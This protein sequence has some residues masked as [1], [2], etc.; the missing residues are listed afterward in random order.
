MTTRA[1][2]YAYIRDIKKIPNLSESH[3]FLRFLPRNASPIA[4]LLRL[5]R[6]VHTTRRPSTAVT[7]RDN[8]AGVGNTIS[9]QSRIGDLSNPC[10]GIRGFSTPVKA[11]SI[12]DA[13]SFDESAQKNETISP[14]EESVVLPEDGVYLEEDAESRDHRLKESEC[15]IFSLLI[16]ENFRNRLEIIYNQQEETSRFECCISFLFNETKTISV[17]GIG[18]KE[19]RFNQSDFLVY[20]FLTFLRTKRKGQQDKLSGSFTQKLG[21]VPSGNKCNPIPSRQVARLPLIAELHRNGQ[22]ERLD[23]ALEEVL[24]SQ[25]ASKD[26]SLTEMEA[27][28]TDNTISQ[29]KVVTTDR[30]NTKEEVLK[31]QNA[32]KDE[33]FPEKK[34]TSTDNAISQQKVVT[35]DRF[36]T[37]EEVLK[38]QNASKDESFPQKKATSTDN[39]ISHKMAVTTD[40]SNT[41]AEASSDEASVATKKSTA[42]RGFIR[43]TTDDDLLDMIGLFRNDLLKA[44]TDMKRTKADLGP[45]RGG[46]YSPKTSRGFR[47][48]HR[49]KYHSKRLKKALKKLRESK[50]PE[51]LDIRSK[52]ADLPIMKFRQ[53]VLDLVNNNPF[54]IIVA[55]TGSGKSTQVPQMILDDAIDREV[56]G[57]C[58]ILCTQ[59]RR[60][61]TFRLAERISQERNENTGETVGYIVRQARQVSE[62]THITFCTTGVLL[63]ILQDSISNVG[64]FS[65]I[66]ID[67]VHVRDIGIDFVMLLLRNFVRNCQGNGRNAPKITLMSATVDTKLFSNYFSLKGPEGSRIFAPHITIPGRQYPVQHHYLDEILFDI[68]HSPH[69]SQLKK[70]LQEDES[71]R[72]LDKHYALFGET[73][74]EKPVETDSTS[75][76]TSPRL[77]SSEED[78]HMPSGLYTATILHILST[79][80]SGSIVC[81]LPGLR[82]IQEVKHRLMLHGNEMNLD[83]SDES[84]FRIGVLHS[85]LPEEQE[86][87]NLDVPSDCRRII[88]STDIAEA[89]VTIPDIK[90]VVDSGK[91]NQ[92]LVDQK[93]NCSRLA[94]CWATQSNAKQRAGRVGRVQ[95]GDYYYIGTKKRYDSL[96]ITPMPE[97]LRGSLLDTCLRAKSF[98]G[99]EPISKFLE[100]TIEPPNNDEVLA[101]VESLKQLQ[102]LDENEKITTLG[103]LISQ[104]AL[105]PHLAKLVMLGIIFRCLDPL[106]ILASIGVQSSLFIRSTEPNSRTL[107]QAACIEFADGSSSDH[108]GALNAFRAV[109]KMHYEDG[110]SKAKVYA[111][112]CMIRFNS[113]TSVLRTTRHVFDRLQREDIVSKEH[114]RSDDQGQVGGLRLNAN[115]HHTP[116]I[117][118]LLLHCLFPRIAGPK[119]NPRD[120]K[121]ATDY[122]SRSMIHPRSVVMAGCTFRTPPKSL[123][124][125]SS[126]VE[127]TSPDPF[128]IENTL[129]SPLMATM[130]GGRLTWDKNEMLMDSWLNLD[131]NTDKAM[132]DRDEAARNL[133]ELQKAI[134][135]V[136]QLNS[137][138]SNGA[139]AG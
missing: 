30:F 38:S 135:L 108:I 88:L 42:D 134:S 124:V 1:N 35:M 15:F 65:H 118:A 98:S 100:K 44:L 137:M 121:F 114:S 41:E 64:S 60:L 67:E 49:S 45:N 25:K 24:N 79:T 50:S 28:S 68:W 123:T 22:W 104:L 84:R 136:S 122:D 99:N 56:G 93:R 119:M 113:Y 112:E 47:P 8:N 72:F 133:I 63:K 102:A 76:S 31:S 57:D 26:K 32:S 58:N 107:V 10:R 132:V 86:K 91:V 29:Q 103:H 21:L 69:A 53:Q 94:N 81:F 131:I 117:K 126:K 18:N 51:L 125:Y 20:D 13:S 17:T 106:L 111:N 116:L 138:R 80:T 83:M 36:N 55:E 96:R 129:V 40:K 110:I 19:V 87:L 71:E 105:P 14:G 89:S 5:R 139:G 4:S 27:I 127:T 75:T 82:H 95:P 7:I 9:S 2:A 66:I 43:F 37:K 39:A 73:E 61:A 130:F 23:S 101:N 11:K 74:P 16:T 70:L 120:W 77:V 12:A 52:V 33:S 97:M 109:R 92:M 85:Q 3:S 6:D 48:Y 54:S 115:S 46:R 78:I 59:P 34:A 62:N 128:I 90:Y